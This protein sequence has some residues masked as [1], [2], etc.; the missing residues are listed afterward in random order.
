MSDRKRIL[1]V[2]DEPRILQG[3]SRMLRTMRQE[4][5]MHFVKNGHDA[6][7][8]LAQKRFD[9][10]VT[11]MRMPG[12]DGA[13]LL[14]QV[15]RRYPHIVR[16]VLS[17][18]SDQ[19]IIHRSI[20]PT[21]QYM[22]KPCDAES[23]KAVV[24]RACVLHELLCDKR[25]TNLVSQM[26]TLPSRPDLYTKI[27]QELQ[28]PETSMQKVGKII[29][30]DMG[31]TAK[32]LQLVNS[33]FYGL[34]QHV[35]S[36]THAATLL[37]LNTIRT[38]VLSIHVFNQFEQAKLPRAFLSGVWNHSIIVS[39]LAKAISDAENVEQK[40]SDDALLAGTLHDCGKLILIANLPEQYNQALTLARDKDICIVEAEMQTFG[41]T[42]AEVGAYLLGLW[43]LPD[44]ICEAVTF[45]HNP[46][47]SPAGQFTALTAVHV[48]DAL[49]QQFRPERTIGAI[50][51]ID[52][53][54]LGEIG[55]AQRLSHWQ[56]IIEEAMLEEIAK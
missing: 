36:P 22:A 42:H 27:L 13:Q 14:T 26:E 41:A 18:Q 43:G 17:G 30:K 24:A 15:M 12:M 34:P 32:I 51:Q 1:F 5:E 47:G 25:L 39:S 38:L 3:L 50:P 49:V 33:A 40:I 37:G 6:L 55:L 20:G 48:A 11:D 31:M 28:S 4:W 54:Y 52:E 21:H 56:E 46:S 8:V 19:E 45:H 44:P 23:L 29:S 35:S 7:D 10:V 53:A 2:D 9:V 16:I